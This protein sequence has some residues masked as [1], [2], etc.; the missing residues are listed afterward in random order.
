MVLK[1]ASKLQTPL[2]MFNKPTGT[3]FLYKFLEFMALKLTIQAMNH[4]FKT[5]NTIKTPAAPI[6]TACLSGILF[7]PVFLV[8]T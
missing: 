6:R 7:H 3:G 2:L 1:N 5:T 4:H 8:I